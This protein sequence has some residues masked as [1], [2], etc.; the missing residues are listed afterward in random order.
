MQTQIGEEIIFLLKNTKEKRTGQEKKNETGGLH[1]EN[2]S[3]FF[4]FSIKIS[5]NVPENSWV[6]GSFN[7]GLYIK[8]Y[9]G[10]ENKKIFRSFSAGIINPRLKK[11][12]PHL[13]TESRFVRISPF[14]HFLPTISLSPTAG[15]SKT[16]P[17]CLPCAPL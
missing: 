11:F 16:Y 10:K 7:K 4:T 6:R 8:Y 14:L 15:K 1:R 12:L 5:L 17:R 13:S 2:W 9:P 3:F